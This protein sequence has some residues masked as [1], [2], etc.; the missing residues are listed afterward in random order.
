MKKPLIYFMI[1]V[2]ILITIQVLI[3]FQFSKIYHS[4]YFF[5]DSSN[6]FWAHRGY[7]ENGESYNINYLSELVKLGFKGVELDLFYDHE[8]DNLVLAHELPIKRKILLIDYL[9]SSK[10]D[11]KYWF[12]IKNLSSSNKQE[13]KNILTDLDLKYDLNN[14]FIVESKNASSLSFLSSV[15]IYTC[16]WV[17]TPSKQNFMKFNYWQMRN[18]FNLFFHE[19]DAISMPYYIYSSG[20]FKDFHHFPIHTWVGK[21]KLKEDSLDIFNDSNLKIVLVDK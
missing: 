21:E 7:L 3:N 2:L 9:Q 10:N 17:N 14:Q 1:V 15:G 6:K 4:D 11:L 19:F 20:E 12:D 8:I 18:K 16:L 5:N 13:V